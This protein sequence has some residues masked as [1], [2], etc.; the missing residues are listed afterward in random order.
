MDKAFDI[1]AVLEGFAKELRERRDY[2]KEMHAVQAKAVKAAD[3]LLKCVEKMN[4]ISGGT[5]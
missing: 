3:D 2:H 1:R 4:F 5:R